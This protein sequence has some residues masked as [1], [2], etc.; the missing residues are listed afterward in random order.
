MGY[1]IKKK[2]N[3]RS[4]GNMGEKKRGKRGGREAENG[5]KE[6]R[7]QIVFNSYV[8]IQYL[9]ELLLTSKTIECIHN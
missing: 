7:N 5:Q 8:Y 1:K 6:A 9:R 4:L 2:K 3:A